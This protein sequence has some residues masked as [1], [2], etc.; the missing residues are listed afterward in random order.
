MGIASAMAR[1]LLVVAPHPDD[2]TLGPGGTLLRRIA[3][4]WLVH[5][6]I[7]TSAEGFITDKTRLER[8]EREIA[9][10]AKCYRFVGVHK[11]GFPTTRLAETP[12]TDLYRAIASVIRATKPAEVLLPF[13]NDPHSDHRIVT[14][15]S[16]SACKSFRASS[17]ERVL[18]YDTPSE[19][20][21]AAPNDPFRADVL[22][23]ISGEH[24]AR[25]I[26]IMALYEGELAKHPF[27]RSG[28][29][30]TARALLYGAAAGV[31][32]AEGFMLMRSIE[33]LT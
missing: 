7:V 13:R 28:E 24:L 23:E 12:E 20:D 16:W 17:V 3:E 21:F 15:I 10:V 1:I 5:W 18:M 11:L 29:A 9:E 32:H 2:E 31:P 6:V 33:L 25:K 19:T 4:G 30:L 26:E 27:P 8:R 14:S 22:V